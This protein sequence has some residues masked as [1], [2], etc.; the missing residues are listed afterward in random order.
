MTGKARRVAANGTR[1]TTAVPKP[2]WQEGWL[3]QHDRLIASLAAMRARSPL[4]ISGD[5]HAVGLG[6]MLRSGSLDLHA[7]PITIALA[8]PIGTSPS[9]WPSAFRRVGPTVPAH[10]DM[11]EEVAP[12]EQ[13]GFTLVDFLPDR[14]VLRF[15][16]WDVKSQSPEAI[17]RL[18]PFHVA[19]RRRSTD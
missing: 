2:F 17:D 18:E 1:L 6:Q 15:F 7:T 11:R 14:L 8:G 5:L 16:K 10:L 12:I 13:H 3:A 9:G 4:V 19:E